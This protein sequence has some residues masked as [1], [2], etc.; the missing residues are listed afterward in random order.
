[1]RDR[2]EIEK[3]AVCDSEYINSVQL[4]QALMIEI[5][6]DIRES[7]KPSVIELKSEILKIKED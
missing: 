1:M 2:E 4:N 3:E 7:I 6:L 5:L